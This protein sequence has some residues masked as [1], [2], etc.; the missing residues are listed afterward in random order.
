VHVQKKNEVVVTAFLEGGR[1]GGS[2]ESGMKFR[3]GFRCG[4]SRDGDRERLF[5]EMGFGN[6]NICLG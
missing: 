5:Y 4:R 3:K 2:V 6:D 1:E